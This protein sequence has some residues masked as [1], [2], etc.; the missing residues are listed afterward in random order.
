MNM[1]HGSIYWFKVYYLISNQ[2]II[3]TNNMTMATIV[4]IYHGKQLLLKNN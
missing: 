1:V 4:K 2:I 3:K